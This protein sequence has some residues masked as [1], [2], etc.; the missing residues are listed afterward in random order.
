MRRRLKQARPA[1]VSFWKRARASRSLLVIESRIIICNYGLSFTWM[2]STMLR[3]VI[4]ALRRFSCG[5]CDLSGESSPT[6]LE[7]RKF[8]CFFMIFWILCWE[9][10]RIIQ[11]YQL[12]WY[13]CSNY[14][15]KHT[16]MQ[17]I[18]TNVRHNQVMQIQTARRSNLDARCRRRLCKVLVSCCFYD[19]PESG[20]WVPTA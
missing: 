4:K 6:F 5:N 19:H 8:Y 17:F 14:L 7:L 3:P 13:L 16:T 1:L 10:S 9:E 12:G 11:V 15:I 20:H 2:L 18:L